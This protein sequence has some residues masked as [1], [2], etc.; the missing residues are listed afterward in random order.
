MLRAQPSSLG[1]PSQPDHSPTAPHPRPEQLCI[2]N[3]NE[4]LVGEDCSSG[5]R[6]SSP[7][8]D[9]SYNTWQRLFRNWGCKEGDTARAKPG[10][11]ARG[12]LDTKVGTWLQMGSFIPLCLEETREA[13][14]SDGGVLHPASPL[15]LSHLCELHYSHPACLTF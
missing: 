9:G 7:T 11:V 4:I 13:Q 2:I 15:P 14:E 12:S 6:D 8:A 10:R 1:F 3:N 5:S